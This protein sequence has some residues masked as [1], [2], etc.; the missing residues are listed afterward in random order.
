MI[1]LHKVV[2]TI[3]EY[4]ENEPLIETVTYGNIDKVITAKQSIYPICHWVVNQATTFE[5]HI[6]LNLS[7]I[8]FDVLDQN[9]DGAEDN[10]L[11]IQNTML[12]V[13]TRLANILR[14][15][16]LRAEGFEL[17]GNVPQELFTERFEDSVAGVVATYTINV[18]NDVSIC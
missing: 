17:V 13:S 12:T 18:K 4:L 16:D 10:K 9:K 8:L 6:E 5:R 3:N 2:D 11:F 1:A 14:R 7:L 15:G